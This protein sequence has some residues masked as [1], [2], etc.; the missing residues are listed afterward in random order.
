MYDLTTMA[1]YEIISQF[2]EDAYAKEDRICDRPVCR[3]KIRKGDP[4]FNV[5]TIEPGQPGCNVCAPCYSHYKKNPATSVRPTR[6]TE[7]LRPFA[8][9][10][11]SNNDRVAPDMRAIQQS[12]NA[13]QWKLTIN[14]PPVV[15]M[16]R[17]TAGPDIM[18]P[19]S[20]QGSSWQGSSQSTG[21]PW[22]GQGSSNGPIGYSSQHALYATECECWA[23]ISYATP[24]AETILIKISAVHEGGGCKKRGVPIGNICEGK[25]GID[26]QIDAPGLIELALDTIVPKLQIFGGGFLWR[27]NEFIVRDSA[28]VDLSNHR[29]SVAYFY[30]Q[31]QQLSCK[32]SKTTTFKSRQFALMVIVPETQWIEY[33][34]WREDAEMNAACIGQCPAC[35]VITPQVPSSV[36]SSVDLESELGTAQTNDGATTSDNRSHQHTHSSSSFDIPSPPRKRDVA[37][38]ALCS[39][40]CDRLKE[41]LRIGGGTNLDM[42]QVPSRPITDLLLDKYHSFSM[43][44]AEWSMGELI[45]DTSPQGLI[46]VG[47]F[48]TAHSGWLTLMAPPKI[49]P[50]SVAHD[51]IVVKRPYHKVFATPTTT[52]GPYKIAHYSLVDEL[53]RLF[54]EANILYWVK[55]LL[56]LTY[57]FIDRCVA[58][59]SEPPPFPIPQVR[60]VEGGLALA[61]FQGDRKP[62]GETGSTCAVFLLEEFINS[63]GEDF[64]KFIHNMDA[65]PLIDYDEY[66]YDLAVFFSFTQHI[67]YAK[68]GKLAF[69]SDYQGS[70]TLLTDPQILT[71]PSVSDGHLDIF[72]DGNIEMTVSQFEKEHICNKYCKW[73][74]FGLEVYMSGE[75]ED[76]LEACADG[77]DGPEA[78]A[79]GEEEREN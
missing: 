15:A 7:Q 18:I 26:A 13:A 53:S 63:D 33:E 72:G 2:T 54:K 41:V 6:R 62:G 27:V 1:E 66:G 9:A 16:P 19:T 51:K 50:G 32:G 11:G 55:S 40:D 61:Y 71:H 4:C 21:P 14:P 76:E 47:G 69:I 49:G 12:V 73:P 43:D 52:T 39:P 17:R 34:N 65:N 77:E 46:G 67:Q 22:P 5:A 79:D 36:Q 38:A 20:W 42:K 56:K 10:Q 74:A 35:K 60:F 37:P 24:P 8:S 64:V 70:T 28:W 45:V 58:S 3:A 68:T 25:K 57:D 30:D 29:W 59:S 31:C 44:T 75:E 78:Y 23:K 48:K